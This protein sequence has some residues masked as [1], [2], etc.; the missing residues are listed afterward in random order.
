MKLQ[1]NALVLLLSAV[2]LGGGVYFYETR[3]VNPDA[4]A[5]SGV[6]SPDRL[7]DFTEAQISALTIQAIVPIVEPVSQPVSQ[8]STAK[9]APEGDDPDQPA[10]SPV[11]KPVKPVKPLGPIVMNQVITIEQ[12]NSKWLMSAPEKV[13]AN[14]PTVLFLTNLLVT[15]KRDRVLT[16]SN[17]RKAEFGL[18]RPIGT[19]D[20]TLT[21]QK[22]HRLV[23]GKISFDRTTLYAQIDPDPNAK[24]LTIA[25]IAPQFENAVNRQLAEWKEKKAIS[26]T[27]SPTPS[28]SASPSPTVSPTVSPIVKPSMPPQ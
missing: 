6:S 16:L 28:A 19:I 22:K 21:N 17:D 8:P 15:G 4:P 1:P 24:E 12:Q 9:I 10:P 11:P 13:T 20:I 26:P 14:Q 23:L 3:K 25:L 2:L 27:A 18:D 7:F 5:G